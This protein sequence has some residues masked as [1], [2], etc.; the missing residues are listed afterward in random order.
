MTSTVRH[1]LLPVAGFGTR[2]QGVD[3]T[4]PKEM[5]PMGRRPVIRFA[6]EEG[7]AAGINHL[8][9]I[10]RQGKEIPA[11]VFDHPGLTVT[12]LH[13][14]KPLG[15]GDALAYAAPVIGKQPVAILYPDN[16]H[17]PKNGLAR[18]ALKRLVTAYDQQGRDIMALTEVAP[19]AGGAWSNSGHVTLTRLEKNLYR[20]EGQSPKG[21]GCFVPRF[22]GELR[23]LGMWVAGEHFFDTLERARR[24]VPSGEEFTDRP[25]RELILKERTLLGL[26]L[27]GNLFDVGNPEGYRQCRERIEALEETPL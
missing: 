21:P 11:E 9:V 22:P 4:R 27:P 10:T 12:F 1:L 23:G 19:E 7:I 15:E 5:L 17:I 16:I 6:V 3:A 26:H 25:I 24:S 2:M 14:K 20:V 13:Q 18:E 8:V